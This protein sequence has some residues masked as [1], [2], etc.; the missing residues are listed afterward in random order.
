MR[1]IPQVSFI[2]EIFNQSSASQYYFMTRSHVIRT[3]QF[4]RASLAGLLHLPHRVPSVYR[5]MGKNNKKI[6]EHR[7][8][9]DL[10][11]SSTTHRSFSRRP[12]DHRHPHSSR[13][14]LLNLPEQVR[15]WH[16]LHHPRLCARNV[17]QSECQGDRRRVVRPT[18]LADLEGAC[19]ISTDCTGPRQQVGRHRLLVRDG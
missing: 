3:S 4:L 17:P 6:Q 2:C 7:P 9:R 8:S 13:L 10:P 11:S 16:D 14:H 18:R 1:N 19:R 15:G 12:A 5:T